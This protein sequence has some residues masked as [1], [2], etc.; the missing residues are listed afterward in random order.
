MPPAA[1]TDSF[2][3]VLLRQ[4]GTRN[5][6]HTLLALAVSLPLFLYTLLLNRQALQIRATRTHAH[7]TD[8]T[9]AIGIVLAVCSVRQLSD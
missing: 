1:L 2:T 5:V 3:M 9:I 8:S 7:F 6:A 4:P